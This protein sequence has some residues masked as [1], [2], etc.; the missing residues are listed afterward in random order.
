MNT[1]VVASPTVSPWPARCAYAAA[2]LFTLGLARFAVP[3]GS[4]LHVTDGTPVGAALGIAPHLVLLVGVLGALAAPRWATVA[5]G[6][7]LP[8]DISSDCS[9]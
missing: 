8:V 5:G 7:W 9:P 4:T 2:A 3:A 1:H 6:V